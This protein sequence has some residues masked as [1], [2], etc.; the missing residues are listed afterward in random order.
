[1]HVSG[2]QSGSTKNTSGYERH[3]PPSKTEPDSMLENS[4][5]RSSTSTTAP[6]ITKTIATRLD[7]SKKDDDEMELVTFGS[8]SVISEERENSL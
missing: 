1:M 5:D 7:F 6:G 2:R 8:K 4:R 3:V